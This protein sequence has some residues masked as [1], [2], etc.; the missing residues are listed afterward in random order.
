MRKLLV[1]IVG[2]MLALAFVAFGRSVVA[3]PPQLS[4]HALYGSAKSSAIVG[5]RR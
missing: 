2:L 4:N 5:R 3:A 1:A